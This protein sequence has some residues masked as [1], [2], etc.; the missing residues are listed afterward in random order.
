MPRTTKFIEIWSNLQAAGGSRVDTIPDALSAND[1]KRLT[2]D[3]LLEI[4]L[5]LQSRARDSI[6]PQRVLRVAFDDGSFDEWRIATPDQEHALGDQN[7]QRVQAYP[8]RF[9]LGRVIVSRA[10]ADG[11]VWYDFEA[12]QL[13]PTAHFNAFLAPALTAAGLSHFALGTVDAASPA[14]VDIVYSHSSVLQVLLDLAGK[15][16]LELQIR[17]D[18]TT[19]YLIDL[20]S[21]VGS[22]TS[23]RYVML[24]KNLKGVTRRENS[25]EQ[26]TRIIPRGADEDGFHATM[27]EARWRVASVSGSDVEL[28]DPDGGEDPIA[29]DNQLNGLYLLKAGGTLTQITDTVR[30]TQIV[31][32]ASAASISVGDYVKVRADSGGTQL[33]YLEAP[34]DKT[35]YGLITRVLDRPE[36]PSVVNL[37]KNPTIK[38]WTAGVPDNWSAVSTPT[39]TE[40]TTVSRWRT[41][42]KSARVETNADGEGIVTASMAISPSTARPYF[43]AYIALYVAAGRVRVEIVTN[44]GLVIPNGTTDGKSFTSETGS[45]IELGVSGLDLNALGATSVTLRVVQDG[46]GTAD[47]YVDAAQLTQSAGHLPFMAGS[48]PNKL[49]AEANRALVDVSAPLVE[50]AVDMIDLHRFNPSVFPAAD[51]ELVLGGGVRVKDGQL[52]VDYTTRFVEIRRDLLRHGITNVQLANQRPTLIDRLVQPPRLPKEVRDPVQRQLFQLASRITRVSETDTQIVVRV[53][54]IGA[55]AAL[56]G[57]STLTATIVTDD[58][59]LAVSPGSPQ[60]ITV[61]PNFGTTGYVDY[62]ITKP[63]HDE[64]PS[65]VTFTSSATG[66]MD[67]VDSVDVAPRDLPPLTM[68]VDQVSSADDEIVVRVSVAAPNT[69]VDIEVSYDDAGLS[70]S[71][72]SPQTIDEG[73]VTDDLSTTGYVE[74]TITRPPQGSP[75]ARVSFTAIGSDYASATDGIDVYANG[76][77]LRAELTHSSTQA[78]TAGSPSLLDFDTAVV[79]VGGFYD[80]MEPTKLTIPPN[81][82]GKAAY[83]KA[84]VRWI[85]GTTGSRRIHIR[86]NGTTVV[87]KDNRSAAAGFTQQECS[88]FD[89]TP[90][91][92]DY[93]EVEAQCSSS[94][95]SE[96][97]DDDELSFTIT[98]IA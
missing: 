55:N 17:R 27:A 71:P 16:G 60:A 80:P 41:G 72:S 8:V 21:S 76:E 62:T 46:S 89:P 25:S 26:A 73:D 40:T 56:T 45:W 14:L 84:S 79:D 7:R 74:F 28:K 98:I 59:G 6:M 65:R 68:R 10:E 85:D 9:D 78:I 88:Y 23:T 1:A 64:Q 44:A 92:G 54:F 63:A 13:S 94:D 82:A 3:D 61:T 52:S 90:A 70:I 24:G 96:T 87:A 86:K 29:F 51:E 37:V 30:S 5:P 93:Y 83:V 69:P 33:T 20:V 15:A 22:S 39:L 34:A 57:L 58:G 95:P 49:W 81:G 42:G 67:G 47:F 48:G 19:Q 32:V 97:V 77:V 75:P 50:I 91:D 66:H 36:V 43:S 35:T 12:L 11:S 2:G 4:E 18:G 38:D 53:A 31:T